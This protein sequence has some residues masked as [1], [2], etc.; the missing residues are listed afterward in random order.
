MTLLRVLGP[1]IFVLVFALSPSNSDAFNTYL[2]QEPELCGWHGGNVTQCQG[3]YNDAAGEVEYND[4]C[5]QFQNSHT[6]ETQWGGLGFGTFA[7]SMMGTLGQVGSVIGNYVFK[8]WLINAGW[9]KMFGG[10]V[11]IATAVACLQLLLMFP[12]EEGKTLNE[13]AGIPSIVFALGDDVVMAI[14]HQ[15]LSMPILILMARLCPA[16]CEG[17]VYALVT[18]IQ[19]VGGT[20]AGIFSKILTHQFVPTNIDFSKLWQLTLICALLKLTALLFLPLVPTSLDSNKSERRHALAG[21][22]LLFC[23]FGGLGWALTSIIL[24]IV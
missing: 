21:V 16:G 9:H 14:S 20:V 17:T 24:A 23:F 3:L 13:Q 15:L 8:T 19:G 5:S 7:Y 10:V 1:I 11:L 2:I 12:N 18:S 6:C 22:F 4:H